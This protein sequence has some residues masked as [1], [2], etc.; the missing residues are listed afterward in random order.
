MPRFPLILSGV[1]AALLVTACSGPS[2]TEPPVVANGQLTVR[3]DNTM[4]FATPTITTRAGQ[5]LELT[6]ENVGDMPH[7]LSIDTGVAQSI[8]IEATGGQQVRGTVVIQQPGT[9]Q[10]VCS[11]PGHAL[12]GMRGTIVAQ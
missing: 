1:C 8:K 9:Y 6:L 12:A 4:H 3:V 5:P 10:F 11:Q 2:S 7:D